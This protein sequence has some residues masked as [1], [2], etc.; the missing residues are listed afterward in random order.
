VEAR[1]INSIRS[2]YP[3]IEGHLDSR[4]LIARSGVNLVVVPVP[5]RSHFAIASDAIRH[6][7]QVLVE[8]PFTRNSAEG[9]ELIH[10][11]D[12]QGVLLAVDH[13]F[14]FTKSVAAEDVFGGS[15]RMTLVPLPEQT[16]PLTETTSNCHGH[17]EANGDHHD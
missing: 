11:A 15:L 4:E 7:K 12:R 14:L 3:T 1:R 5:L 2:R 16:I 10:L 8:K 6:G 9:E 17:G 13:T